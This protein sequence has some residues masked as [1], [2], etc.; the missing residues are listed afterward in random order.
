M[1]KIECRPQVL[2]LEPQRY[3]LTITRSI[4]AAGYA[5][6][7]GIPHDL[8]NHYV[9]KSRSVYDIWYHPPFEETNEFIQDLEIFVREH[10]KLIAIFP[11]GEQALELLWLSQERGLVAKVLACTKNAGRQ[12][13]DKWSSINI[14]SEAG[15]PVIESSLVRNLEE[16]QSAV[17]KYG[18]PVALKPGNSVWRINGRKCIFLSSDQDIKDFQWPDFDDDIG[19]IVQPKFT[20]LRH[21]CMFL[22]KDGKIHQ[23][24]ESQVIKTDT[25]DGTGYSTDSISIKP[26]NKRRR[27]IESIVRKLDYSSLGC[28]QFLVC[29]KTDKMMFLELNPRID[30]TCALPVAVGIDFPTLCL[31]LAL[32]DRQPDRSFKNYRVGIR[33]IWVLGALEAWRNS[34]P[35]STALKSS[36]ELGRII[37]QA[38]SSSVHTTFE[39]TDPLPSLYLYSSRLISIAQHLPGLFR[40][41]NSIDMGE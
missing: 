38:L 8:T 28:A 33:L 6:I 24:F 12:C 18:L 39:I 2:V 30:A 15:L 23:Y 3:T 34:L 27:Y 11:A 26:S 10:P 22:A 25:E 4:D 41:K 32:G 1:M 37:F 5:A 31:Q 16:L 29:P 36:V 7:L 35:V 40:R 14:A 13:L 19:L 21:N 17:R 9:G 20:G